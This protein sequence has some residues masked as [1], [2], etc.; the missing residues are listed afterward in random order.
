MKRNLAYRS[1][2]DY[3]SSYGRVSRRIESKVLCEHRSAYLVLITKLSVLAEHPTIRRSGDPGDGPVFVNCPVRNPLVEYDQCH[4]EL[5]RGSPSAIVQPIIPKNN[6]MNMARPRVIVLRAPGTNCDEET[7]AAWQR[8][9]AEVETWHINRLIKSRAELG[10]FQ[11]LTIPGGFSYGDD[12]GA[13]RILATRIRTVL[14]EALCRFHDR[15][16]LILGICNGFQVL[17]RSGLLPGGLSPVPATLA[18]NDSGRFEALGATLASPGPVAVRAVFGTDRA[19]RGSWRG[20]IRLWHN[21]T[22]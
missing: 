18:Q 17:V 10:H 7:V 8:V 4:P 21:L 12:L 13:G 20:P 16:G 14:D 15:G 9:G 6:G 19:P 11:I 22:H 3:P 1:E 5:A 2:S